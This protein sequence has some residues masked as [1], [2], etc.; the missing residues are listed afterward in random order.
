MKTQETPWYT[1]TLTNPENGKTQHANIHCPAGGR[2]A[3]HAAVNREIREYPD[4]RARSI[5]VVAVTPGFLQGVRVWS[6]RIH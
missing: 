3:V 6:I 4:T 2:H 1:V 5:K